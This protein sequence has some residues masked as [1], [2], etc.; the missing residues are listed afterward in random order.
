MATHRKFQNKRYS[1]SLHFS[2]GQFIVNHF[3]VLMSFLIKKSSPLQQWINRS[4][5][6]QSSAR[7]PLLLPLPCSLDLLT[8]QVPPPPHCASWSHHAWPPRRLLPGINDWMFIVPAASWLLD[9]IVI[10]YIC[11]PVPVLELTVLNL[12][13]V[14]YS[15]VET[16]RP[17][18]RNV[19]NTSLM[20][21]YKKY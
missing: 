2:C 3:L 20:T 12:N 8:C 11:Y 17:S 14:L 5:F 7:W 18:L 4:C 13:S 16:G 6:I 10:W 1:A 21:T 15:L 19:E 9:E